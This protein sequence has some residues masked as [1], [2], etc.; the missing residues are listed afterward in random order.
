MDTCNL[1][2]G[3]GFNLDI[4]GGFSMAWLAMVMLF[5]IIIFTRK[6]MTESGVPFNDIGAWAGGYI[7]YILVVT[8]TCST[9]WALLAGIISFL[10]GAFFS[11]MLFGDD[12][13]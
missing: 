3:V 7:S 12:G 6:I 9:K 4:M 8:F 1:M 10:A 2:T 13:Y 11:G 5:F